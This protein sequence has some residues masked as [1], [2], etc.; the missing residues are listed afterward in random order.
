[1]RSQHY[2]ELF[3]QLVGAYLNKSLNKTVICPHDYL[4][5]EGLNQLLNGKYYPKEWIALNIT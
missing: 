4:N 5:V 2:R 3:F 1:M